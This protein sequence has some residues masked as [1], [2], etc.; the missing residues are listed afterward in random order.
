MTTPARARRFVQQLLREAGPVAAAGEA[1]ALL[2]VSELVT[3]ANLHGGGVTAFSARTEA[4]YQ[5]DGRPP[6]LR[7]RVTVEDAGSRLPRAHPRAL[8]DPARPGGR[9]WALA[10]MLAT[11]CEVTV[12]SGGGKRISATLVL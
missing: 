11:T 9:G 3:N 10:R 12:L 2:T 8:L 7:L 6:G 1:D 4:A 5:A